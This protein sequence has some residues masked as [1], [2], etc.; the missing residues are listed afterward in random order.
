VQVKVAE[1]DSHEMFRMV[2]DVKGVVVLMREGLAVVPQPHQLR[3]TLLG[4]TS[5]E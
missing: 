4:K 3:S 1:V 2:Q 5:L